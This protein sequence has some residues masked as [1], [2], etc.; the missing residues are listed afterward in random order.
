VISSAQRNGAGSGPAPFV[1]HIA[2]IP[3]PRNEKKKNIFFHLTN[4]I[5]VVLI[6]LWI[7]GFLEFSR[8]FSSVLL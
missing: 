5:I 6:H 7:S 1:S 8:R 3:H 4:L 2:R